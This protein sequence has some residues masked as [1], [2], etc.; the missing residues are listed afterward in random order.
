M[1]RNV[2]AQPVQLPFAINRALPV[3]VGSAHETLLI[4]HTSICFKMHI[5]R[6]LNGDLLVMIPWNEEA[7]KV[8]G[9]QL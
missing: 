7:T 2:F 4:C 6:C 9:V 3:Y 8:G 5:L 1:A